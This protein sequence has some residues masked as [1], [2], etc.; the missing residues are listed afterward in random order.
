[1]EMNLN[2]KVESINSIQNLNL[3]IDNKIS[4]SKSTGFVINLLAFI[5]GIVSNAC[6]MLFVFLT[7]QFESEFSF[8]FVAIVLLA[9]T[10]L[11]DKKYNSE[12]LKTFITTT[13][14]A[15]ISCLITFLILLKISTII[16]YLTIILINIFTIYQ[17]K[18]TLIKFIAA[19]TAIITFNFFIVKL[20]GTISFPFIHLLW[21]IALIYMY[22]TEASWFYERK[23][24]NNYQP[25]LIAIQFAILCFYKMQITYYDYSYYID[26]PIANILIPTKYIFLTID[27]IY[28]FIF[29]W[30]IYSTLKNKIKAKLKNIILLFIPL[31][32]FGC[33]A[34]YDINLL[35]GL[36]YITIAYKYKDVLFL[37]GSIVFF[38]LFL[39]YFYYDLNTTLLNK[40]LLLM[41][42]G[43][44]FLSLFFIIKYL[45]KNEK[46]YK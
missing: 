16:I 31:I 25:I 29:T 9:I 40:S 1:M 10:Y 24:T 23:L 20:F 35:L 3:K 43:V 26:K 19:F 17:I 12:I 41:L 30:I 42:T 14:L 15:G 36:L 44:I 21:V 27:I 11:I 38:I 13:F 18:S 6:F 45:T 37:I 39:G 46:N 22:L 4:D 7:T 5:G 33:I 28:Y 32:A 2:D 8:L 34:Y